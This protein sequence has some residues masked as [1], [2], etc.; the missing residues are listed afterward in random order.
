MKNL[1]PC[2][3]F[4]KFS[5]KRH[6][7]EELILRFFAFID[8]YP[9]YRQVEYKGVAKYLDE[10]L[11]NGNKNFAEN[12]LKSKRLHLTRWLILYQKLMKDKGLPRNQMQ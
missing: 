1:N 7:E 6:E 10:Y 11:D 12:E 5:E 8:A 9:D 3:L 2:V 4:A